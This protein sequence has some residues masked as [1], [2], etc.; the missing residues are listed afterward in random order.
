M[1]ALGLPYSV[2][3]DS[4]DVA[5]E[6]ELEGPPHTHTPPLSSLFSLPPLPPLPPTPARGKILMQLYIRPQL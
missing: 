2:Q 5:T 4:Y 3:F 1:Q 6:S